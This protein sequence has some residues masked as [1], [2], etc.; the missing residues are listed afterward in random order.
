MMAEDGFRPETA[1]WPE[2]G[3]DMRLRLRMIGI[4]S[5]RAEDGYLAEEALQ[6]VAKVSRRGFGRRRVLRKTSVPT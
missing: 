2:K 3:V 4:Y 6:E 5:L 1:F